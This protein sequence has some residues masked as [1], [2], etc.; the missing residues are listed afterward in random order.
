[1][2]GAWLAAVATPLPKSPCGEDPRY[3]DDFSAIRQEMEK[4]Q[5]NDYGRVLERGRHLLATHSKDL[6]VAGYLMLAS[7]HLAGIAGVQE[8]A[9]AYRLILEGFWADCH[10]L[11][12]GARNA[13]LTWLNNPR[14]DGALQEAATLAGADE[15]RALEET[16]AGINQAIRTAG[17]DEAPLWSAPN[18]WLP[19]KLREKTGKAQSVAVPL[20]GEQMAELLCALS[21]STQTMPAA[22]SITSD[23]EMIASTKAIREFLLQK[24]AYLHALSFSRTLRWGGLTLPPH[25]QGK[26]RIPPLRQTG[27]NEL[28][29]AGERGEGEGAFLLCENLFLEPGGQFSLDLQLAACE[30]A[31]RFGREDLAA[32]IADQTRSLVRRLPEILALSFEDGRP[33]ASLETREWLDTRLAGGEE[34]CRGKEE[35]WDA[36]LE[37][38]LAEAR[39]LSPKK[40]LAEGLACLKAVAVGNE[41]ERLTLRL[42]MARLCLEGGRPDLALPV[43]DDLTKRVE[44][45]SL[46]LW[47]SSLALG[48]WKISLEAGRLLAPKVTGEEAE[49]LRNK[50][51]D[52]RSLICRADPEAAARLV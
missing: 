49:T 34:P 44:E 52:L 4:L 27:W 48:I 11:K 43:L 19:G 33:F 38:A 50:M 35:G 40:K 5:G 45:E 6:R 3:H 28:Q 1:M 22:G 51:A 2:S 36:L 46:H 10:P 26:T 9:S 23:R 24:K 13:A 41:K 18:H 47:D 29:Q 30:A 25:E 8:A 20:S 15:L 32:G 37:S 42:T 12:A 17:G 16:V 39:R 14:F 31:G 21:P 7:T